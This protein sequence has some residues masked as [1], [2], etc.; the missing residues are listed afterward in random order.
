MMALE[1]L[2]WTTFL[3]LHGR[4]LPG[5]VTASHQIIE[6]KDCVSIYLPMA[7]SVLSLIFKFPSW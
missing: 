1:M 3:Q 2:L 4:I 7:T 6:Y 5:P